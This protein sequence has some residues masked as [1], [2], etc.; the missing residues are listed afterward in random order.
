MKLPF[1]MSGGVNNPQKQKDVEKFPSSQNVGLV[2]LLE[3]MVKAVNMG[4]LYQVVFNRWCFSSNSSYHKG[5]SG[6]GL[7]P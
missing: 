3:T 6:V 7:E 2:S 4:C 5:E 1:E